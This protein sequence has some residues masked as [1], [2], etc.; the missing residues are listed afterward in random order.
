MKAA[1]LAAQQRREEQEQK[2]EAEPEA[3]AKETPRN[4]TAES[5]PK[6]QVEDPETPQLAVQKPPSEPQVDVHDTPKPAAQASL[7]ESKAVDQPAQK[8]DTNRTS[9][10][11][12][13]TPEEPQAQSL[14]PPAIPP[15][16]QLRLSADHTKSDSAIDVAARPTSQNGLTSES[17]HEIISHSPISSV[18]E[19]EAQEQSST[20]PTSMSDT[21]S[22]KDSAREPDETSESKRDTIRAR[23][24]SADSESDSDDDSSVTPTMASPQSANDQEKQP[25]PEN[26]AS[27]PVQ[28]EEEV[29]EPQVQEVEPVKVQD[30]ETKST[31]TDSG[32]SETLATANALGLVIQTDIRAKRR[33]IIEPV[34]RVEASTEESDADGD[35]MT[36]DDSFLEELQ[37]ATVQEAKPVSMVQSPTGE[38]FPSFVPRQSPHEVVLLNVS[39]S[40]SGTLSPRTESPP[41]GSPPGSK[42]RSGSEGLRTPP[43]SSPSPALLG[44]E[45]MVIAKRSVSSGISQRIKLLNQNSQNPTSPNGSPESGP[46]RGSNLRPA[47]VKTTTTMR[48][49]KRWS[50]S[51]ISSFQSGP[52]EVVAKA[53]KPLNTVK[54]VWNV[55]PPKEAPAPQSVS[56]TAHIVR[57]GE[58]KPDLTMPTDGGVLEMHHS[59]LVIEQHKPEPQALPALPVPPAPASTLSP[60]AFIVETAISGQPSPSSRRSS[61]QSRSWHSKGGRSPG[62]T[63]P[64]SISNASVASSADDEN[65]ANPKSPSSNSS[66]SVK[67]FRRMS[68]GLSSVGRK[69]ISSLKSPS[70]QSL[71]KDDSNNSLNSN[72]QS[73]TEANNARDRQ[74]KVI[75]DLNV[76]FPDTLLW[77]RRWTEVD[78]SG[79]LVFGLEGKSEME[80][81]GLLKRFHMSEFKSPVVPDLEMMEMP[82][83]KIILLIHFDMKLIV[84]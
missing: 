34:R 4:A 14:E 40:G 83:S 79:N 5:T 53:P 30:D 72:L 28:K 47:P 22:R 60:S 20:R 39:R 59:P 41:W 21:C 63:S 81:K 68:S 23:I 50:K 13:P 46:S 57:E 51:S 55:A 3:E 70:T 16:S 35:F 26:A 36:D 82:H 69:G 8:P 10:E 31:K 1:E 75:G 12:S 17:E 84:V 11:V 18:Q 37:S 25:E 27:V 54:A 49:M 64:R 32:K 6:P 42:S 62:P 15:K 74:A 19:S 48:A 33:P 80:K 71:V 44:G 61:D 52:N 9:A 58:M 43:G 24:V 77:K 76:Q 67:F 66:R 65:S 7:P 56:V 38:Y 73:V 29:A 78:A 2:P 45:G